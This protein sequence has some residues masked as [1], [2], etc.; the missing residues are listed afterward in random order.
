M[1]IYT[2]ID[3]TP[4]LGDNVQDI[5]YRIYTQDIVYYCSLTIE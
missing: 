5:V 4:V 3:Q 1:A 2:P